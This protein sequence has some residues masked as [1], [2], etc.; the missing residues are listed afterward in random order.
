LTKIAGYPQ[1]KDILLSYILENHSKSLD[2]A[3]AASVL[4]V[5]LSCATNYLTILASELPN[6]L[7]YS[8]GV[9]LVLSDFPEIALPLSVRMGIKDK[10]I[11]MSKEMVKEILKDNSLLSDSK[12]LRE[13]LS[14]VV[15]ALDSL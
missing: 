13:E 14:K 8:R 12:R 4:K 11:A 1:A 10:G 3:T 6:S 15:K 7:K 2:R 9:L 5:S